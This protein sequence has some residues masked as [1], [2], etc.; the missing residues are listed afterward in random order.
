MW[1]GWLGLRAE[2]LTRPVAQLSLSRK[3]PPFH[4]LYAP[5]KELRPGGVETSLGRQEPGCTCL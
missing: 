1:Q 3:G 4:R 2:G 5:G